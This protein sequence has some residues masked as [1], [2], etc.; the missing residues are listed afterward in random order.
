MPYLDKYVHVFVSRITLAA[1]RSKA[2]TFYACI[3][4]RAKKDSLVGVYSGSWLGCGGSR[5]EVGPLWRR[6]SDSST[7]KATALGWRDFPS[8]GGAVHMSHE[9]MTVVSQ[10]LTHLNNAL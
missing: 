4:P 6:C 9:D 10:P 2:R 1:P 3:M 7:S 8:P 5:E